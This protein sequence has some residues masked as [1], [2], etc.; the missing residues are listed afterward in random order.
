MLLQDG[1][2]DPLR[3]SDLR[4]AVIRTAALAHWH[5]HFDFARL[6]SSLSRAPVAGAPPKTAPAAFFEILPHS[7]LIQG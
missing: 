5:H 4:R 6:V 7:P 2:T 1:I 3:K